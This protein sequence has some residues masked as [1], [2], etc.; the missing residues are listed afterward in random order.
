MDEK[1][2]SHCSAL[3]SICIPRSVEELGRKCFTHCLSLEIV[4]IACG[5]RLSRVGDLPLC[6]CTHFKWI[7][8][9]SA[10]SIPPIIASTNPYA[11]LQSIANGSPIPPTSQFSPL[12]P[13]L[14]RANARS[15]TA[16]SNARQS[17]SAIFSLSTGIDSYDDFGI[18]Y[19]QY[20]NM[21]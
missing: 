20:L 12:I 4:I 7:E 11:F 21:S 8:L 5:T 15:V 13:R 16:S 9:Q 6:G 10:G 1:A 14:I 19:D 17:P 2:F 18:G 3:K